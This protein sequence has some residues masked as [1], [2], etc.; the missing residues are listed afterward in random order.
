LEGERQCIEQ[1]IGFP[2]N[3]LN[4]NGNRLK[5]KRFSQVLEIMNDAGFEFVF[6]VI[7]AQT[8]V[9]SFKFEE[10]LLNKK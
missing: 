4:R 7:G 3:S 1:G 9:L 6:I 5:S 10:F 2:K 8:N